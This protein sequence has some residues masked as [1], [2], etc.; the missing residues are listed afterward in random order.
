[1]KVDVGNYES[2]DANTL[3]HSV[4]L[5]ACRE[6]LNCI[7]G[8]ELDGPIWANV[9]I[10]E[11]GERFGLYIIVRHCAGTCMQEIARANVLVVVNKG[12]LCVF[13]SAAVEVEETE[14]IL[15]HLSSP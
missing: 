11:H 1:M 10:E 6:C 5:H 12:R 9:Y 15:R 3:Y 7:T 13:C 4:S 2:V 14:R 8:I